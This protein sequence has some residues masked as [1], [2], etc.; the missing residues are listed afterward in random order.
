MAQAARTSAAQPQPQQA[1]DHSPPPVGSAVLDQVMPLAVE[2]ERT[3]LASRAVH[4]LDDVTVQF[5]EWTAH[6]G[7]A[8]QKGSFAGFPRKIAQ[9]LILG[10]RAVLALDLRAARM[11]ADAFMVTK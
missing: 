1:D 10:G 5:R 4:D 9:R 6:G 2:V 11:G 7:T 8:Y 3:S